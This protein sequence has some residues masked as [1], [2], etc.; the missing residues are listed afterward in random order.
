MSVK[1]IVR[2]APVMAWPEFRLGPDFM[3]AVEL[4]VHLLKPASMAAFLLAFW[5]FSADLGWTSDFMIAEG[6]MSHWQIW[7]ALGMSMLAG[8]SFLSRRL[9]RN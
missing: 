7:A 9:V 1:V 4:L 3:Q 6:V 8:Q 5:R 2:V